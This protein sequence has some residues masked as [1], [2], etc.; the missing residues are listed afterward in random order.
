MKKQILHFVAISSLCFFSIIS[1]AQA[2]SWLWAKT[3]G[4]TNNDEAYAVATDASGN[5]YVAGYFDSPTITFGTTTLT[6]VGAYDIF[7][8]KYGSSGNVIWAKSAG[9]TSY[10]HVNSIAVDTSGNIYMAGYFTSDTV[11]FGT[12]TLLNTGGTDNTADLFLVKYNSTG[13][14]LWAKSASG[15]GDD[16]ANSVAVN[17]AGDVYVTGNFTSFYLAF[18]SDTLT[19]ADNASYTDDI[20]IA[21]YDKNGNVQ[22]AEKA[23]ALGWDEGNSVAVDAAGNAYLAGIFESPTI[24]FGSVTLTNTDNSGNTDDIFLTKY[25][26]SGSVQWAKSAIGDGNDYDQSVAVDGSG[27]SYVTGQFQSA[28]M[29]MGATTLTNADV[30]GNN[31]DLF[32]A[33][34]NASGNVLWAKS[35]QGEY[36]DDAASIALDI[37]GNAYITGSFNSPTIDFGS[38]T[39]TNDDIN[40]NADIF[41]AKY[42]I[43]GNVLWTKRTG[44]TSDDQAYSIALDASGNTYVA[45]SYY[46]PTIIFGS[47]TLTNTDNTTNTADIF[48]AKL[49]S[50]SGINEWSISTDISIY[51]N[52]A[53]NNIMI[54]TEQKATIEILNID[55]QILKTIAAERIHT[56][57]DIS[58]FASGMYFVKLKTEKDI[59]MEKFVK[60]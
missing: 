49:A 37:H 38:S 43:N 59:E 36:N 40:N 5:A 50:S 3:A 52:P 11:K 56:T 58:G 45:G 22:W 30:S 25:N 18:G 6:N 55:G 1:N 32:L 7:L 57:I 9:G 15:L 47:N 2:P 34:Y 28:T 16:K 12:N 8:V 4:G 51:P 21:K 23:G 13:N 39:L 48:I 14:V 44:G 33:K 17:A 20:F 27:N 41:V 31:F 10:E 60:E 46:S 54:T 53:T 24:I 29:I 35:A 26:G 19:N 42:D